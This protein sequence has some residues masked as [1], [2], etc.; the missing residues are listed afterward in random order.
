MQS[1]ITIDLDKKKFLEIW[2]KLYMFRH[3]FKQLELK[4]SV[5]KG[6]HIIIWLKESTT[7]KNHFDL[8]K[9]FGDDHFRIKL[10]KKRLR[11]KE[12]INILFK[13][14][15]DFFFKRDK[16]YYEK[17]YQYYRKK[18]LFYKKNRKV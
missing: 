5:R 8:R 2:L 18:Y 1:R 13:E 11:R 9:K 7:N 3:S 15:K 6:W 14:K 4:R 16:F 12:P 10:D 17:R